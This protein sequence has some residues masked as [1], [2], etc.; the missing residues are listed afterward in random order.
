MGI[1][2]EWHD[3]WDDIRARAGGS[4]DRASQ[5]SLFDRIDWYE[6]VARHLHPAD[7]ILAIVAEDADGAT[8]LFLR[9]TGGRRA[10]ALGCWYSLS[11][12]AVDSG[13]GDAGARLIALFRALAQRFD[14]LALHPLDAGRYVELARAL[15]AAGW[16]T[17]GEAISTH[18]TIDT[19]GLDFASYWRDRP[20][21]L[22]STVARRQRRKALDIRILDHFEEDAW[23]DY[24]NIYEDSWKP[25]EG[26]F[27]FLRAL[28]ER[29]G[30]AGTLRLGIARSAEGTAV[31]AQLW[32]VENGVATI[33]KLAH[34]E[35]AKALSPGSLLSHAMFR[36]AIDRDRV[37]R[38][39]FG[40]GNEPYKAEWMDHA[41]P[42]F[43]IDA[44]RP[45]SPAGAAGAARAS[46]SRLAARLRGR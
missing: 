15:G 39:S 2:V 40:L 11:Y 44:F 45:A 29:E 14:V 10:V 33:H 17:F 35:S 36:A 3:R 42:M 25:A 32:L 21:Q 18:W 38:I 1:A 9:P 23:Q 41:A 16:L 46:L 7:P 12:G 19:A 37:H 4:L 13:G 8:W 22:R 27:A 43:R 6:A 5:P 20:G 34:R 31:A 30:A 28:A 26:S 24:Q